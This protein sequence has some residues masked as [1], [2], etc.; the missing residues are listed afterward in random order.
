[1]SQKPELTA[2]RTEGSCLVADTNCHPGTAISQAIAYAA[3]LGEDVTLTMEDVRLTVRGDSVHQTLADEWR[4][5]RNPS[6][7]TYQ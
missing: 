7:D 2:V 5:K 1:M 4:Y 6:G 3:W